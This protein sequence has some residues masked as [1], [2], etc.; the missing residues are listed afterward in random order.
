MSQMIDSIV[1]QLFEDLIS[2]SP[3]D[4]REARERILNLFSTEVGV[5]KDSH[6]FESFIPDHTTDPA[7]DPQG[8]EDEGHP[9]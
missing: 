1:G 7:W 9:W 6:G 2:L 4:L 3:E 8:P 5:S